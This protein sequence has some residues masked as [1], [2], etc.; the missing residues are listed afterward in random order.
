M[1]TLLDGDLAIVDPNVEDI[2]LKNEVC[3]V[4]YEGCEYIKRISYNEKYVILMSDNPDRQT[5]PD[6]I[7]LKDENTDFKCHGVAIEVRRKLR[8]K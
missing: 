7:V 8:R 2:E 5:Y 1:P 4:T 6:I 3:V